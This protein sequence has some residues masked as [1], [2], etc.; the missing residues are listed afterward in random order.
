MNEANVRRRPIV[1]IVLVLVLLAAAQAQGPS[2]PPMPYPALPEVD[3]VGTG[4]VDLDEAP[5]VAR[6][7]IV[8]LVTLGAYPLT[9]DMRA[10][11]NEPLDL[12]TAA[13]MLV[14]L[15]APELGEQFPLPA[16]EA[17][18]I[19]SDVTGFGLEA[20]TIATAGALRG[21]LLAIVDLPPP[22]ATELREALNAQYPALEAGNADAPVTRAGG[23]VMLVIALDHLAAAAP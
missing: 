21:L 22:A 15:F 7:A 14:N 12:S 4:I 23:A 5:A 10:L 19:L 11:P 2:E 18:A 13:Y 6:E 16:G 3:L 17:L 20:D 9:A 8:Q 1:E